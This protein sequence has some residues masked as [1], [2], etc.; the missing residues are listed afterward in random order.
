MRKGPRKNKTFPV[1]V[2]YSISIHV[3]TCCCCLCAFGSYCPWQLRC[4]DK[5]KFQKRGIVENKSKQMNRSSA[6]QL[7][8]LKFYLLLTL[9][10]PPIRTLYQ[11]RTR[12][13]YV[14]IYVYI[15]QQSYVCLYIGSRKGFSA[16]FGIHEW[17]QS[18]TSAWTEWRAAELH[19]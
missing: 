7:E 16:L 12:H 9:S 3:C 8:M 4:K 6:A 19:G 1:F 13:M 18:S 15:Q 2:G 11:P 5:R 17:N 14:F 10:R